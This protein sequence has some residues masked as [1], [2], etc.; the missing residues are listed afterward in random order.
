M[1]NVTTTSQRLIPLEIM[2]DQAINLAASIAS[3]FNH[4]VDLMPE[5]FRQRHQ[6]LFNLLLA[7]LPEEEK[8]HVLQ[9]M[10]AKGE[11]K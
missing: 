1:K 9:C 4:A 7:Q 8:T 11:T 6:E 10:P 5:E 2:Q 3:D